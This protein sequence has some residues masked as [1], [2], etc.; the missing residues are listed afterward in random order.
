[1]TL[2]DK[3]QLIDRISV[4]ANVNSETL[5]HIRQ[6]LCSISERVLSELDKKVDTKDFDTFVTFINNNRTIKSSIE[7]VSF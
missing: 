7:R 2:K 3:E 6:Y 5:F 4:K 1:M